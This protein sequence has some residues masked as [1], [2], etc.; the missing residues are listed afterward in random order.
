MYQ[1]PKNLPERAAMLRL[2]ALALAYFLLAKLGLAIASLHPS[3]SPVWPPSGLALAAVLLFGNGVWPVIALGAFLAN[4]TTFGSIPTSLII[5]LGNTLEAVSTAWL[6]ARWSGTEE[7]FAT[8][9]RVAIFAAF[10]LAP[11]SVISAAL[12]VGALA[13]AGYT[14]SA[15]L[16]DVWFT[17]W[18]GDVGGQILVAPMLFLW[19]KTKVFEFG[20]ADLE[21]M[22]MLLAL[23]IAVGLLA[24]SPL[25]EQT[26]QRGALAF[27]ATIP[28]LWAALRYSQRDTATTAFLLSCFAIWG[29]LANGGPFARGNLNDSFL[30]VLMFV[31]STTVPSLVLSADVAVRK[32][33]QD[34][35][36][37]LA[38]E[39]AHRS[40]NLLAVVQSIVNNT[41]ARSRGL[42]QVSETIGGRLQ[43]LARAQDYMMAGPARATQLRDFV[44]AEM[45]AFGTRVHVNGANVKIGGAFAHK[46][47]LVLHELATNASKYG[48]MS[49][50]D[51]IVSISWKISRG[52]EG[53]P[54]LTFMWVERNG[55]PASAPP[56]QGFGME[57]IR[58]LLGSTSRA[59]FE[60]SGLQFTFEAPLSNLTDEGKDNGEV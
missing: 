17:W 9:A 33:V 7:P 8:P 15:N 14:Y 28:L 23:T 21:K 35:Q 10:A 47:A 49:R 32:G 41:L 54:M 37:L 50:P 30:L 4:A 3:A 52:T 6:I 5:A 25:M 46:L 13:L 31:L 59:S 29:T 38:R 16:A 27:L 34:K 1:L 39:L 43:A 48:S 58:A 44:V 56:D 18:L 24:F 53:S 36:D 51:G 26:S 12:G 42:N 45:A 19:A 55:P 20:R 40:K 2:C 22:G 57:L 60:E 11:G